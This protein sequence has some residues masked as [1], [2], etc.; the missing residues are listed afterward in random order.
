MRRECRESFPDETRK[1]P[2]S[3]DE[4]GYRGS[5]CIVAGPSVFLSSGDVYVRELLELRQ[6]CERPDRVSKGR[7]DFPRDASAKKGLMSPGGENLL[8][9]LYWRQVTLKI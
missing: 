3:R 2:S 4:E 1:E 9:F 8:D 7:Y 5:S 6:G